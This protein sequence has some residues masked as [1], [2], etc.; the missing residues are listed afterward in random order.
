MDD[1]TAPRMQRRM[2]DLV[3]AAA[4]HYGAS[5]ALVG[6]DGAR[7]DF[8]SFSAAARVAAAAF[9]AAGVARGDRI[10]IWAPNSVPWVVAAAGLQMAGAALVPL[11]TRFKGP[12]AASILRKTRPRM[13]LSVGSF[14]GNDYIDMLARELGGVAEGRL[15]PGLPSISH[16]VLLDNVTRASCLRWRDF[17]SNTPDFEETRARISQVR[18][19]DTGDILFTSGTTGAPKGAMHSQSQALWMVDMWNRANDLRHGDRQLVVNP[20]F[21]SFGYRSGFVSGLMA[22]MATW[23]MAVFDPLTV[24]ETVARERITVL[25]GPPTLFFAILDH[26]RRR[27]FDLASLRVA[28][29]GSSNVPVELIRRLTVDLQFDLVLTSYGLTESTAL[30]SANA[31]YADFETIARTVGQKLPGTEIRIDAAAGVDSGEILV[32]GPNVMQGYF[33]DP[34]GTAATIDPE[35]WLHTGDVGQIDADGNLRVLDRLKDVVIV[36]GFNAY[37]A[38]IENMLTAHP[39]VAEVAIVAVP[40]ARLGEVCGAAIVPRAGA[41]ITLEE[42]ATWCRDRMANY[43]VPRHLL[44]LDVLPRTALGKP[45]KFLLREQMRQTLTASGVS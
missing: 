38:E 37:P 15:F 39:A 9:V 19:E 23:P 14:L 20:F 7:L 28:H 27:E 11:N 31:P 4:A 24:M 29:T 16:V 30:V 26:P 17:L 22:G 6:E 35:G 3:E 2:A 45:Q 44:L 40:D 25:M 41:T 18:P 21:H 13:L 10:A 43:K 8:T 5:L 36:G 33:E 42:L 12:E 1:P 32:R 34:E